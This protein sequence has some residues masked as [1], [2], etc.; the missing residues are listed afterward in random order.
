MK[1]FFTLLFLAVFFLT[2]SVFAEETVMINFSDLIDDYQGQ[3]KATIMDFSTV[4]GTRYT[5]EEKAAM[6]TSLFVPN[7]EVKLTS[8][9]QSVVN[10][11]LSY[12]LGVPVQNDVNN[13]ATAGDQIMGI[14]VH[15]P[16]GAFNGYAVVEPPFEIPPYA[17]NP[18]DEAA[19]KGEQ[20]NGYGVVPNVGVLKSVKVRVYGMNFPM[21]FGL[22]LK[23]PSGNKQSIFM[24]YLDFDGWRE[25]EWQNPNYVFDVRNRE[26]KTAPIY[27]QN[28][29]SLILDS[30]Y[31]YRDATQKGG[32][33]VSYIKDI[34]LVYD[35]AVLDELNSDINHE[36]TWGIV[37]D[38]E[39]SRNNFELQRLGNRQVLRYLES[40]KMA[41]DGE[42]V[43]APAE[44]VPPSPPAPPSE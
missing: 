18:V 39:A 30:L 8:S 40:Q 13:F 16:E 22:V 21:G 17:T 14:R 9:S 25:L 27:P 7:W 28:Q 19:V 44:P 1:R 20:F 34:S 26:L 37:A 33:F 6:Q 38:R 43:A 24:S 4:A 10:N 41:S 15:F 3:N 23:D 29:P 5:E 42:S 32:D 36:E 11:D 35:Q 31:V 12:V 2:G